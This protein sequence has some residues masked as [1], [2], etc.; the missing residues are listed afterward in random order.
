VDTGDGEGGCFVGDPNENRA[1]VGLRIVDPVRNGDAFGGGTEVVIIDSS[2]GSF[3]FGAGIFE[4]TNQL[5]L[6][7][8]H[9]QNRIAPLLE[10]IPLPAEV[11]ELAVAVSSGTGRDRLTV[12]AQAIF[13]LTQKPSYGVAA[14]CDPQQF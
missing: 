11:A 3:P 4:V 12:G 1:T 7:G 10:P 13:H 6:F 9:A 5:P 8:I 2:G 14:D